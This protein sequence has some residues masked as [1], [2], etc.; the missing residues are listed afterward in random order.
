MS[1]RSI[2]IGD[3][4][5]I[6]DGAAEPVSS[7][8]LNG[9]PAVILSVKKQSGS[10]S[11]AVIDSVK[12]RLEEI[13]PTLP[14]GYSTKITNDQSVFTKAAV[15]TVEEH[16]I[17]GSFLASAVVLVFL[18]NWR[19]TLIS[20]LAIPASIIATFA[21][22]A[23][24]GFT[25]NIITLLA[26]TLA[27][28]IVIDDAIIVIENIYKFLEEKQLKPKEA[29]IEGTKEIGLAVL[30]TTLSLIAVFLP[31]AFMTGI[32][33]RFL[34]SFGLTM[35]FAIGVSLVVAFTLTPMLAS[36]WLKRPK[37]P[38]AHQINEKRGASLCGAR[39]VNWKR[40]TMICWPY[41]SSTD[42]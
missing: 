29:A 14:P 10:N 22:M 4:A 19:S 7:A 33:G 11:V 13:K 30:A 39:S 36:R 21:L 9:Q 27:V 1:N 8:S 41:R 3:V 6:E 34:N 35:A 2:R 20:A 25:L 32:V 18:W 42:G 12:E 23:A 40:C 38:T 26:L 16:L 5:R 37:N 15:A 31:V 17:L 28:G 24:K